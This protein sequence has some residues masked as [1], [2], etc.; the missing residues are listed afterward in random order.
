[1]S[2][3][4][5]DLDVLEGSL[6]IWMQQY[7]AE[8]RQVLPVQGL[9]PARAGAGQ[10]CVVT[11]DGIRIEGPRSRRRVSARGDASVLSSRRRHVFASAEPTDLRKSFDTL[12]RIVKDE[13]RRD[14]ASGDMFL[15]VN[16]AWNRAKVL[17]WDGTGLCILQKC[18]ER[19]RF[20]APWKRTDDGVIRMTESELALFIE[21]SQLVFMGKLSPQEVEPKA[22]VKR[23]LYV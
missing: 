8:A 6:R 13:L 15:F 16:R 12:A 9:A 3:G 4:S 23:R 22:V 20:A 19:G 5:L 18:L 14:P 1:M 11:P 10:L 21:G 17:W 2:A 7:P